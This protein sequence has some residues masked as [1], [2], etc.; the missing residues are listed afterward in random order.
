VRWRRGRQGRPARRVPD[1]VRVGS[2]EILVR[3]TPSLSHLRP[4]TGAQAPELRGRGEKRRRVGVAKALHD[5]RDADGADRGLA[6][7]YRLPFPQAASERQHSFLLSTGNAVAWRAAGGGGGAGS[8]VCGLRAAGF[9]LGVRAEP[10]GYGGGESVGARGGWP[11]PPAEP[12]LRC[13][14]PVR[15]AES[16]R[17]R[18]RPPPS[19][20]PANAR[21]PRPSAD[22]P[23]ME[24][25]IT[26]LPPRPSRSISFAAALA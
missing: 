3:R 13:P 19:S 8:G 17:S 11:E 24:L 4:E 26:M 22:A 23:E 21:L 12:Q 14:S 16:A 10:L 5:S 15:A 25:T 2:R 7:G 9:L 1:L 20:R 6:I 18:P